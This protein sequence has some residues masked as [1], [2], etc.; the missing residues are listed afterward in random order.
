M[1]ARGVTL[2]LLVISGT[3]LWVLLADFGTI[4]QIS[5][6]V[7]VGL[8]LII[9]VPTLIYL[10]KHLMTWISQIMN[11]VKLLGL[12]L[13]VAVLFAMGSGLVVAYFSWFGLRLP[14]TWDYIHFV[15]SLGT[16]AL[17]L[18]HL[19]FALYRRRH[20]LPKM[21]RLRHAVT[22]FAAVQ[23]LGLAAVAAVLALITPTLPRIPGVMPVP[24]DY[25]LA[26]YAQQFDEYRGNPFAP[27]YAKTQGN[28]LIDPALLSGSESCGS[29]GCH[30]QILAEW[31]P[32]AHRFSAMNP[33]FQAVQRNFAHERGP[34]ETRYCAGCHDPISLF[35]GAKSIQ[36]MDLS[37]PGM[38]EGTSCVACHAISR[39]DKRGNA[40]YTLT[41]PRKYLWEHG[42]GWLKRLSDFLIRAYPHQHLADYDRNILRE[43]EFCG[44]CHKQF[45]PEALN[46]FGMSPGQNQ[47]DEW[48]RSHWN[49]DDPK[50]ELSCRD[51]HMRL[52]RDSLD[53]GRGEAGDR[54]RDGGDRRHRHH[55]FVATNF[56]MPELLQLPGWEN[57]VA[58]TMDWVQ[59]KT[60]IDEIRH[61]WPDGPTVD[62]QIM[63]ADEVD[64]GGEA[65]IR[66][67]IENRKVGHNFTTGPLDFLR[68]WVHLEVRDGTG[69]L[70]QEWG[71][72]DPATGR[73]EDT[74]G[75]LHVVG[76][77][78]SEGTAVYEGVPLDETGEPLR[79][80]Q[81]WKKAGGKGQRI[82]FPKYS[83]QHSYRFRVPAAVQGP[84]TIEAS[85]DFK[86]YRQEFLDLVFPDDAELRRA[87]QQTATKV[88]VVKSV[89][90]RS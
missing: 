10:W 69:N 26:S 60:V 22:R 41:P 28:T 62:L 90:I 15:S 53:P 82:I 23:L 81:L 29:S 35:A 59:G 80:H 42:S 65:V 33:P 66:V 45:I 31:Q 56:V 39:V 32:S 70:L 79:K 72:I 37:A 17:L 87:L 68:A 75:V 11:P 51:C 85:L 83:D 76:N 43:P 77:P 55:G 19:L 58:L 61:I 88:V 6:L 63:C 24:E 71:G 78:R 27:T 54:H 1:L 49:S 30:A 9:T 21:P 13:L 74:S 7:H 86:R 16:M 50:S 14:P 47:F 12:L 52:V 57:H 18:L 25:A 44:A 8:G 34:E 73:I 64:Q 2:G 48:A 20:L 46:R 4:S 38:Q 40:D 36:N 84:L 3:G 5:L 89:A 67:L